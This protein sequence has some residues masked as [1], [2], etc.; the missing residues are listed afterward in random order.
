MLGTIMLTIILDG[1]LLLLTPP[2][3]ASSPYLLARVLPPHTTS[4][5]GSCL[6]PLL[7][8][9]GTTPLPP[10]PG[11]TPSVRVPPYYLSVRVLPPPTTS[12]P[13]LLPLPTR[14]GPASSHYDPASSHDV[15]F[16]QAAQNN[17]VLF[18]PDA[19]LKEV[20]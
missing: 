7:P 5:P 11:T 19:R 8:R 9:L 14:P 13:C 17:V 4:S 16:H 20:G 15:F 6:L 3:P 12:G 1:L 18:F 10:H 2:T